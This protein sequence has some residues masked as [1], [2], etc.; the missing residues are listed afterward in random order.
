MASLVSFLRI[1]PAQ[2]VDQLIFGGNNVF[3]LDHVKSGDR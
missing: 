1:S 2:A 3:Q